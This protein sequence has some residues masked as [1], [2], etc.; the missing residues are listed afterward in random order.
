VLPHPSSLPLG[1]D[2][3]KVSLCTPAEQQ[4]LSDIVILHN[5]RC[6]KSRATL[7]LLT[8]R[9]IQP[10]VVDYLSE[11]PNKGELVRI[12]EMLGLTPRELMRRNEPEYRLLG[13][14]DERLGHAELVEAMCTHPRL[15]ER[16]IVIANGKAAIG[17]P[18]ES[19]L[20]I[21]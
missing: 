19:V 2:R 11:P 1:C 12:L 16:P 20:D 9:G 17:R 5:P 8:D 4:A 10:T 7:A 18:P 21:L 15:I 13:L 14:D 6:S 3:V